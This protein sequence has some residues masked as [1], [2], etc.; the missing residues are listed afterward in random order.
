[1]EKNFV[2]NLHFN[3]SGFFICDR[4]QLSIDFDYLSDLLTH[5]GI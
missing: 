5:D 4:A 2:S 1:M 3:V